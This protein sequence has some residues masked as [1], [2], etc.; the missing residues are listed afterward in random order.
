MQPLSVHQRF[1]ND[2]FVILLLYVSN[3]LSVGH[4]TSK[5]AK[6]KKELSKSF[7]MKNLGPV[8]QILGMRVIHDIKSEVVLSQDGYIGKVH[9]KFI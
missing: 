5:I 7:A 6:L 3:M 1:S 8:K 2:D 9:E 4:D